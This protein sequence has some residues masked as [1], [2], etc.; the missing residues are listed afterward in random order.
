MTKTIFLYEKNWISITARQLM[1]NRANFLNHENFKQ[2]FSCRENS[3][4]SFSEDYKKFYQNLIEAAKSDRKKWLLINE[5]RNPKKTQPNITCL[6]NVLNDY[7]TDPKKISNLLNYRFPILSK[8]SGSEKTL[9]KQNRFT[10]K[11][12]SLR[13]HFRKHFRKTFSKRML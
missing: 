3:S 10:W 13:K 7:V 1:I 5:I 6:K 8:F 2:I 12:I 11:T 9:P 4:T